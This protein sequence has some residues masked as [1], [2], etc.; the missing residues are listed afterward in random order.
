MKILSAHPRQHWKKGMI[1]ALLLAISVSLLTV[2]STFNLLFKVLFTFPSLYF[3][4]IGLSKIFSFGWDLPPILGC[5]PK[6]PDSSKGWHVF[7]QHLGTI[8]DSHPLWCLVPKNLDPPK[9]L[10]M[11]QPI[12]KLQFGR[13]NQP[14]GREESPDF[15]FE[16]CPLHSPLLKTSLL[17]SFFLRLLICLNSPGN[18]I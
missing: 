7:E 15:K 17:V 2:S 5:N 13:L 10:P 1:N 4:A 9:V 16:L 14:C 12:V 11:W 18:L 3:F 8:R 6:Q